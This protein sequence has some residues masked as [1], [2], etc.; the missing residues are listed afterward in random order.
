MS[1]DDYLDAGCAWR[2][3]SHTMTISESNSTTYQHT[4]VHGTAAAPPQWQRGSLR[5][6]NLEKERQIGLGVP[7][8]EMSLVGGSSLQFTLLLLEREGGGGVASASKARCRS[9]LTPGSECRTCPVWDQSQTTRLESGLP[10]QR[11]QSATFTTKLS[12]ICNSHVHHSTPRCRA[13]PRTN[14]SAT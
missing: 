5:P 6:V 7:S 13:P 3:V 8:A 14:R 1:A 4:Y 12:P 10:R 2:K 9:W 11:T